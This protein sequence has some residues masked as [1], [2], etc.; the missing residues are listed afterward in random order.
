VWPVRQGGSKHSVEALGRKRLD[1]GGY[2]VAKN[3]SSDCRS[4]RDGSRYIRII[5]KLY[6]K[7]TWSERSGHCLRQHWRINETSRT[8]DRRTVVDPRIEENDCD[9]QHS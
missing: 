3:Y 5:S 7:V 6:Y 9:E 2:P 4:S 1:R 8:N